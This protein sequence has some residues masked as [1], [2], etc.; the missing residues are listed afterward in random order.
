MRLPRPVLIKPR[1]MKNAITIS[2]IVLLPKPLN[3]WLMLNVPENAVVATPN[4]AIAPIGN[5]LTTIP[6][7]VATKIARRCHAVD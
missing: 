6:T 7:M 4:N 2:Q 1:E 5:G 3:A